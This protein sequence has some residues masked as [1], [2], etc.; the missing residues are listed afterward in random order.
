MKRFTHVGRVF[1]EGPVVG[2]R[3]KDGRYTEVQELPEEKGPFPALA[4][5][6]CD[7]QVNGFSGVDFNGEGPLTIQDVRK[8]TEA[9]WTEGCTTFLPTLI[10]NSEAALSARFKEL[11]QFRRKDQLIAASILG[12]HLEGPFISPHDG[13]RGAHDRRFVRAPDA[14]M[15]AR[16]YGD[17]E[18]LITILTLSPEWNGMEEIIALAC[19]KGIRVSIGH[20]MATPEQIRSAARA[21]ASLV[22]HFGNGVPPTIPRHP[23]VLWEQLASEELSCLVIADGFHLPD[24]VLTVAFRT[25]GPKAFVISDATAF[26]GLAPGDYTTP[27]GGRVTLTSNGRLH[28]T[29]DPRLLAGS[30]QSIRHGVGH[31]AR[32]GIQPLAQALRSASTLPAR[33]IGQE[34]EASIRVGSYANLIEYHWDTQGIV[35]DRTW[36]HGHLVYTS[37]GRH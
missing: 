24:A 8:A 16:L 33:Y 18:E 26:G 36:L 31:L 32:R 25:K 7:L 19:T 14:A 35:I 12:Y 10:T 13:A 6:M 22:T 17:A 1:G 37:E 21:G 29:K 2:L 4:P 23:N 20:T 5:G 34:R 15:V 27:I 11:N 3:V 28:L 30:A 9:L